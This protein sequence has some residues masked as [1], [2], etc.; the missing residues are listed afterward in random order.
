MS[1]LRQWRYLLLTLFAIT[2][3]TAVAACG[4]D[5]DDTSGGTASPGASQTEGEDGDLAE[6]QSLTV[7]LAGEP[8]HL[9]P[10]LTGFD[11]DLS[12]IKQLWRGLL[13][14]DGP[15]LNIVPSVATA[16]PSTE[17][18]GISDDG[19]TYSFSL[20]D[21][22]TWSDGEPVV[23]QNFVDAFKRLFDP[24]IG[25]TGY[26]YS[27]YT[28]I[29]GAEEAVAGTGSVDDIGVTAVNDYTLEIKLTR[30]Q[31]T[32]LA[33]I[34][35]WPAFPI[36][37]DLIDANGDQWTEAGKLV[38]NGPFIMTEWEHT[39]HVTMEA[40]PNYWGDDKPTLQTLTFRMQPD[41]AAA[42]ISYDNDELD[43]TPIPLPDTASFEGDAEQI[44]FPE[45]GIFALEFNNESPPFDNP[46][47]RKAFGT[48]VDR[49]TYISAVRGGVGRAATGWLPPGIPGFLEERG[50][51]YA[52]DPE[53]AKEFL[54]DAGYPNG[55]GLPAVKV[56]I[57][58]SQGGRLAGEFLKEQISQNLGVEIEIEILE[59]ETYETRYNVSDFQMVFGGWG[60]D[61]ADPEN[62]L[63]NL[64]GTGASGNQYKYSNPE[65]DDLFAQA[66]VELD[67]DKRIELY[68]QAEAIII[69][70]DLGVAPIFNR[71][72]NWLV[73][74]YV[75]GLDL[76]GLDG[77]VI[78]DWFFTHV[79]IKQ[80]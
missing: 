19:L 55:D 63:P 27:F 30:E 76:T 29:V 21:D 65:V 5:D 33:L 9:D 72:R 7:R 48:A 22:A 51:A 4:D 38:G 49:D 28:A 43:V 6:D 61:Y 37:Q 62:F 79:K 17:N 14:Y 60:A 1:L 80:H 68:Q 8:Q 52:F 77:N 74:D 69:D 34:A 39:D 64:F 71:V 67:N 44:K 73:K 18:G 24:N 56:T 26:Y 20:R 59:S 35:M 15:D 57:A 45:L 16:V 23:A 50:S 36:R 2:A 42:L 31:P 58:D 12:M 78:G 11:V 53:K 3:L 54:T 75:D 10:Q 47:V 32:M 66:A 70:E 40:N 46:D 25:A 41:E 13:Y